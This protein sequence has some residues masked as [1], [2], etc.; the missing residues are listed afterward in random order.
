MKYVDYD[1]VLVLKSQNFGLFYWN[2]P[3]LNYFRPKTKFVLWTNWVK[4]LLSYIHSNKNF[5][6]LN[7]EIIN[8]FLIFRA[9]PWNTWTF[10]FTCFR[11]F[12]GKISNIIF[13]TKI[14]KYWLYHLIYK[15][16]CKMNKVKSFNAK[17]FFI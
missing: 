11:W 17:H 10:R 2:H 5:E 16:Y 1:R 8:I 12:T 9:T 15:I 3:C 13:F 4:I 14:I 6:S 7:V